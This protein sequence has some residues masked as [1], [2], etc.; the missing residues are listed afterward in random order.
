MDAPNVLKDSR[1]T[2]AKQWEQVEPVKLNP[3]KLDIDAFNKMFEQ[4]RM[5]DPEEDGYGDW[6]K[7]EKS[8]NDA[9]KFSGKFNRDVFN[10]M[11][12]EDSKQHG[13][14]NQQIVHHQ[15]QSLIMSQNFGVELGRERPDSYTSAYDGSRSGMVFTDLKQA[16]TECVIPVTEEDYERM[17]KFKNINDYQNHREKQQIT[18]LSKEEAVKQLYQTN[19]EHEE[20]SAAPT[21]A[22]LLFSPKTTDAVEDADDDDLLGRASGT[23]FGDFWH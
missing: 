15:P 5:P 6:L 10:Q 18:P 8:N 9:P 11:F 17:P 4:T 16:Y 3:K 2:D 1:S 20:E 23:I 19:K 13:G 22:T 21:A 7:D 12:E 14:N